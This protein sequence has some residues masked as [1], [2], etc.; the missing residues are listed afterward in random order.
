MATKLCK[1]CGTEKELSEFNKDASKKNGLHSTCKACRKKY[2]G[3]YRRRRKEYYDQLSA[4][5]RQE[6]PEYYKQYRAIYE[7]T[8]KSKQ[9]HARRA[10]E[11]RRLH[12][13]AIKANN[14][15]NK[16][17]LSGKIV[18][19]KGCTRCGSSGKIEAHHPD[20]SKPLEVEF[21]CTKCH[22]K[23]HMRLRDQLLKNSE[24]VSK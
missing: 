14:Q 2:Q 18:R 23:E 21:L 4:K 5:H 22:I 10:K 3:E 20:Y 15:V 19:P 8:D 17:I 12:P 1:K 11:Q 7:K 6:N 9:A 13:E 16:A 24:R